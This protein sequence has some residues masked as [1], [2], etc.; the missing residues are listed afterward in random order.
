MVLEDALSYTFRALK[1][2]E[3]PTFALI[4]FDL[5]KT[6]KVIPSVYYTVQSRTTSVAS[7]DA[8]E[9]TWR[10]VVTLAPDKETVYYFAKKYPNVLLRQTAW[11][12]RNLRL[13]ATRRYVYWAR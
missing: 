2:A 13:K 7:Q 8:P 4:V 10:A 6:N 3:L 12:G 9:P 5:Q 1:F 11:D